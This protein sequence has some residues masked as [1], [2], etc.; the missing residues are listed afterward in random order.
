MSISPFQIWVVYASGPDNFMHSGFDRAG[1]REQKTHVQFVSAILLRGK[2][3][4]QA[5][6]VTTVTLLD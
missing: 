1:S 3:A 6:I 5:S 2:S 4:L